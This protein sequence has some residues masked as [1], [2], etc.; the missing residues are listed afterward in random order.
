MYCQTILVAR[1]RLGSN[2]E[3]RS[4]GQRHLQLWLKQDV[5][6]SFSVGN[7]PLP[8][9]IQEYLSI[10]MIGFSGSRHRDIRESSSDLFLMALA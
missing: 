2:V 3:V 1:T 5:S 8:P 9:R 4:S 6:P 10:V 7:T